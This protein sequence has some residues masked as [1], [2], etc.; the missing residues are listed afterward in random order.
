MTDHKKAIDVFQKTKGVK[1]ANLSHLE[2]SVG[3]AA[4]EAANHLDG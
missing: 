3:S 2:S 4:I 1:G